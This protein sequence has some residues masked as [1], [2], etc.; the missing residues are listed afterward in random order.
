MSRRLAQAKKI[1]HVLIVG[2]NNQPRSYYF[3]LFDRAGNC[4]AWAG[5]GYSLSGS[6][7]IIATVSDLEVAI[8]PHGRLYRENREDLEF[9]SFHDRTVYSPLVDPEDI[10]Q[11][12]SDIRAF[13]P[14]VPA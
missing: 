7:A 1:N 8:R 11:Y 12:L 6:P 4:L 2:W 5:G 10:Q 9:D 13:L 3:Q 14:K